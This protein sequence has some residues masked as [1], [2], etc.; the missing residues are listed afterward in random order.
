[1]KTKSM[2][3]VVLQRNTLVL[4]AFRINQVAEDPQQALIL[5]AAC[6]SNVGFSICAWR[7]V[8]HCKIDWDSTR[9]LA[10]HLHEY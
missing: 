4:F 7:V 6:R 9:S 5:Q 2:Q 3:V 1:M 10:E 8:E